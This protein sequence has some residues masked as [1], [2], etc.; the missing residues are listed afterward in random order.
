[1][2][3]YSVNECEGQVSIVIVVNGTLKRRVDLH[4][5]TSSLTANGNLS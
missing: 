5:S 4:L 2:P 3:S 1:M